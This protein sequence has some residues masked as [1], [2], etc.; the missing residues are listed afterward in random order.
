MKSV[1]LQTGSNKGDRQRH[2]D[3]AI[4]Q[5]KHIS[6][7]SESSSVYQSE[8]WG[9][10]SSFP[11]LNQ[12]LKVKTDLSPLKLLDFIIVTEINTGRKNSNS[13]QD[14]ELDIDI[15][16]YE[17]LIINE[18]R[19]IIPHPR[20]HLR[21]FT[22]KPLLEIAPDFIHPVFQKTIDELFKECPDKSNPS[23]LM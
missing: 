16:F 11:F 9:Y 23:I 15:L 13:Y 22:L 20:L 17:D 5:L 14:R 2:L 19:L 4:H 18:E 8:P 1:F 6:V 12:C 7:I 21:A 3:Y 10:D